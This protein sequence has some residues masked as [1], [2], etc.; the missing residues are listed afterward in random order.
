MTND[1]KIIISKALTVLIV[2]SASVGVGIIIGEQGG[3]RSFSVTRRF[4][5]SHHTRSVEHSPHGL[6]ESRRV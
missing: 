3:K 6:L 1:V 2:V 4:K 5:I